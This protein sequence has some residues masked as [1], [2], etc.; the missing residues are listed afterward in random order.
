M[1]KN[2]KIIALNLQKA[3]IE[4]LENWFLS[5]E[6]ITSDI[7]KDFIRYR[8]KERDEVDDPL[9]M[10]F[11]YNNLSFGYVQKK[12]FP[13]IDM[14]EP[15]IEEILQ[16]TPITLNQIE[17]YRSVIIDWIFNAHR[18]KPTTALAL[19][20]FQTYSDKND[21]IFPNFALC[22]TSIDV[23]ELG[24]NLKE[25][26]IPLND[27]FKAIV[28]EFRNYYGKGKYLSTVKLK[29]IFILER[30]ILGYSFQLENEPYE[31]FF[32][33]I[34]LEEQLLLLDTI[35]F[36]DKTLLSIDIVLDKINASGMKSLTEIEMNYLT[37]QP[38]NN[39]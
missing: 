7:T 39:K 23:E 31:H 1:S 29:R 8:V 25:F 22:V 12:T 30:F 16:I 34:H 17:S 9:E 11:I 27:K 6:D 19:S 28:Q 21:F 15:L 33:N 36:D 32:W 2:Q 26:F 38:K 24:F 20:A 3:T 5:T 13:S 14:F 10:V 18:A 37:N 35:T 4:N